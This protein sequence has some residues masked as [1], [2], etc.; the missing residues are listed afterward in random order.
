[1][2][3]ICNVFIKHLSV[4]DLYSCVKVCVKWRLVSSQLLASQTTLSLHNNNIYYY[5]EEDLDQ[6]CDNQ[7]HLA[8]VSS[9][10]KLMDTKQNLLTHYIRPQFNF[11]DKYF[12][13]FLVNYCPNIRSL[14][15][16]SYSTNPFQVNHIIAN[17]PLL[18]CFYVASH[19]RTW[20]RFLCPEVC[21]LKHFNLV[22]D[23]GTPVYGFNQTITYMNAEN[24]RIEELI[25]MRPDINDI[26]MNILNQYIRSVG[27]HLKKFHFIPESKLSQEECLEL[28]NELT[29]NETKTSGIINLNL[30][31]FVFNG[32]F[33]ELNHKF[34]S[35]EKL[36]LHF[37][38]QSEQNDSLNNLKNLKEIHLDFNSEVNAFAFDGSNSDSNLQLSLFMPKIPTTIQKLTLYDA[39]IS[40]SI[41]TQI[42]E[43]I[44]NLLKLNLTYVFID[45]DCQLNFWQI[46]ANYKRLSSL[47]L[48]T[49][50]I[51]DEG[52][53]NLMASDSLSTLELIKYSGPNAGNKLINTPKVL[54][55]FKQLATLRIDKWFH[56]RLD[57]DEF[58]VTNDVKSSVPRNVKIINIGYKKNNDNYTPFC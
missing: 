48:N 50:N 26:N 37:D 19:E 45:N 17:C 25:I 39:S 53:D 33:T 54:Q 38:D 5:S 56:L 36:F 41:L 10:G 27:S 35:I 40:L 15:I 22:L 31:C 34:S 2:G 30:N 4:D 29:T 3:G 14:D 51:S 24:P 46:I 55:L 58:E 11:V 13:S 49:T 16:T 23:T 42:P 21:R 44:P 32:F 18:E 12:M 43:F 52:I 28:M 57:W 6:K 1:M 47:A 8:V 7:K 20:S 9:V